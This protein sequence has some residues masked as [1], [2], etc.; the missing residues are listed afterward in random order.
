MDAPASSNAGGQARQPPLSHLPTR[1]TQCPEPGQSRA[2][3]PANCTP[4]S[5]LIAHATPHKKIFHSVENGGGPAAPCRVEYN[6]FLPA[7]LAPPDVN[8]HGARGNHAPR[9]RA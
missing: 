3:D 4:P 1:G 9:L 7:E 5:L 8:K 6:G 2:S